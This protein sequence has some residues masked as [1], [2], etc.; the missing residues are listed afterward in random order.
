LIEK[1]R[2]DI[3]FLD[4]KMPALSGIEVAKEITGARWVVFITAYDREK[5]KTT[6][7]FSALQKG[8][9]RS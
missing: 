2:P 5:H 3:A 7:S 8:G 6:R 9:L 1:H 4:I